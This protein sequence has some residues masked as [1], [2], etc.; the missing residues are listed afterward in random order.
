MENKNINVTVNE[1]ESFFAHE[2]SVNFNPTQ[3]TVDFKN[4]TPRVDMRSKDA[5][6]L[7]LKHNVVMLE[8]WHA[9]LVVE[10]L[11][12][13][14]KKYEE[15]FGKIQKPDAIKKFEKERKKEQKDAQKS[16][17]TPNYFG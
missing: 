10:M 7:V 2:V 8:P 14:L 5:P 12:R 3:F 15:Q 6:N 4:I 9:K 1:G 17:D 13:M 11:D 16:V